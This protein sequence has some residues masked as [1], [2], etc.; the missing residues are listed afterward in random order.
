MSIKKRAIAILCVVLTGVILVLDLAYLGSSPETRT[1]T[2]F[3][4]VREWRAHWP[5]E[6]GKDLLRRVRPKGAGPIR[7]EIEPHVSMLLDPADSV[8]RTILETGAWE[9][10]TWL[11]ISEHLRAGYT[12]IDV[13]AHIGYFSLKAARV[14]GPAGRVISV[15]PNPRTVREL[16]DNI[17]ESRAGAIT[18]YP[19]ACSETEG[20]LDLFAAPEANTGESSLSRANA[21]QEGNVTEAYKVRARPLDAIIRES[22]VSRADVLKID[23]EG[24]EHLVLKGAHETLARYHPLLIIEI[25][26]PQLKAMGATPA[27]INDYL[28]ALGY[29]PRHSFGQNVEYSYNA[30]ASTAAG[31]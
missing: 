9:P 24:A 4:L 10:E 6:I 27:I 29:R 7:V 22:N 16:Q 23:V 31:N 1:R 18:V 30:T 28:R 21:S 5:W 12:F 13:G 15:E 20:S 26:E 19:V 14:V 2:Y 3:A 25:S 11:A 17:R 8:P